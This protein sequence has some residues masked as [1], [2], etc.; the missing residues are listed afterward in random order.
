M[1]LQYAQTNRK[2]ML[3]N[4]MINIHN[5]INAFTSQMHVIV[6]G[7]KVK[8]KCTCVHGPIKF[9]ARSTMSV[10]LRFC[11]EGTVYYSTDM[12]ILCS[13]SLSF[14][15]NHSTLPCIRID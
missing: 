8:H 9:Y 14:S 7:V 4:R 12:H 10:K 11:F 15:P 2:G 5:S 6:P 3:E 1:L 13:L